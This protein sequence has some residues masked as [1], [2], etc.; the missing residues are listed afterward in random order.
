ML[1]AAGLLRAYVELGT[2]VILLEIT[3][4]RV[5]TTLR[6]SIVFNAK[7]IQFLWQYCISKYSYYHVK[8]VYSDPNNV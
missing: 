7:Y 1:V 4:K 6:F 8:P 5:N 3:D 2:Y